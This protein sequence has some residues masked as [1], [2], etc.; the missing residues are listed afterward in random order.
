[1]TLK[2]EKENDKKTNNRY[3]LHTIY[4]INSKN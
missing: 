2:K 3:T 4:E 1:M